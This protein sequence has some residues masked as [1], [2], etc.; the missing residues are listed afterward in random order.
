VKQ[1]LPCLVDFVGQDLSRLGSNSRI[2]SFR[3]LFCID[4]LGKSV[5]S[6]VVS[7]SNPR[8]CTPCE[9]NTLLVFKGVLLHFGEDIRGSHVHKIHIVIS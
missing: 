5:S 4:S 8:S 1:R 2:T 6:Q 3:V 9:Y 7:D